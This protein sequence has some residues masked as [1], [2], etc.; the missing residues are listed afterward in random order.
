M[1]RTGLHDILS[2]CITELETGPT[3]PEASREAMT[4]ADVQ[5]FVDENKKHPDVSVELLDAIC[6]EVA[7]LMKGQRFS[8]DLD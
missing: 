3:L 4:T 7:T 1:R 8:F 6:G 2:G 5:R